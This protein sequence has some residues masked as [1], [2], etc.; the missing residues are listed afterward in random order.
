MHVPSGN[1]GSHGVKK[2]F[3]FTAFAECLDSKICFHEAYFMASAGSVFLLCC[4]LPESQNVI[5][6]R[7]L[8]G[9]GQEGLA[10]RGV[11]QSLM[12]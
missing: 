4:L 3:F 1:E 12:P 2:T 10:G 7:G 6:F 5:F 11:P 9:V 8:E